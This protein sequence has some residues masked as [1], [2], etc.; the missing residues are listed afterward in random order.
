MR[1]GKTIKPEIY[2]ERAERLLEKAEKCNVWCKIN[3]LLYPG[4]TK[5]TLDETRYWLRK[6]K[7]CF[8]G[9][10]CNP[11][12]VYLNGEDIWSYVDELEKVSG[13]PVDRD[14]LIKQGYTKMDLSPTLNKEFICEIVN[15]LY[16]E[17]MTYDDY[18]EL[19]QMTYTPRSQ[20]IFP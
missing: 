15:D 19:K 11:L 13:L 9:I 2:L 7:N 10:S 20:S 14:L 16:S 5:T 8:K 1:M 3:V 12:M 4:E 17:F 6:M 18:M